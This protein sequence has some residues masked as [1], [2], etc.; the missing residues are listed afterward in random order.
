MSFA[1]RGPVL[2]LPKKKKKNNKKS[3]LN[4]IRCIRGVLGIRLQHV[5]SSYLPI[6]CQNNELLYVTKRANS[7]IKSK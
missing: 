1:R 4:A 7:G 3:F 5:A 2:E 6:I